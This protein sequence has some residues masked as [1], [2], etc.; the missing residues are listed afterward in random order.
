MRH[1]FDKGPICRRA[2]GNGIAAVA[3]ILSFSAFQ[4]GV[5]LKNGEREKKN[6]IEWQEA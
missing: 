2:D 4:T 5:E 6:N 1:A 3:F